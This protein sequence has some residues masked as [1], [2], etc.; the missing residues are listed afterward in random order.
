MGFDKQ[1]IQNNNTKI[2]QL[3]LLAS[4][5]LE[6]NLFCFFAADPDDDLI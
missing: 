4:D 3:S 2:L 6:A 1:V 5:L